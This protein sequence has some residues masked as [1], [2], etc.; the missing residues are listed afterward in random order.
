M[1]ELRSVRDLSTRLE[2]TGGIT[3]YGLGMLN[4]EVDML[5]GGPGKRSRLK[6]RGLGISVQLG[7]WKPVERQGCPGGMGGGSTCSVL[8]EDRRK[9]WKGIGRSAQGGKRENSLGEWASVTVL[10][11]CIYLVVFIFHSS[12]LPALQFPVWLFS[13]YKVHPDTPDLPTPS[14]S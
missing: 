4:R 14:E 1:K 6:E 10:L 7:G 9:L 5:C 3:R 13:P 8:T 12:L 11:N 2:V